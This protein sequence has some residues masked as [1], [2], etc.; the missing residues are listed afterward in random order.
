MHATTATR[1]SALRPSASA[2][3]GVSGLSGRLAAGLL[4][5]LAG[6]AAALAQPSGDVRRGEYIF[7]AAG[8]ASCHSQEEGKGPPLAGGLALKTPYGTFYTPNITPDPVH[9]IGKWSEADFRRALKEGVAPD[10]SLYYPAF[11]YTSYTGMADQDVGDLFAYLKTQAPSDLASKPHE[12]DFPYGWRFLMRGWRLAFFK[13]GRSLVRQDQPADVQRGAYLVG[14]VTH[15]GEC[16]T[17]RNF[18]GA[19]D[20]DRWLSGAEKAATG[21]D[22]VPNITPDPKTGIGDWTEDN[23]LDLLT[24]GSTPDGDRV[25]GE[26]VTTVRNSS[27]QM[28]D[29]DRKAIAHYLKTVKPIEHATP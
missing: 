16:H 17:P 24:D 5:L 20:Y 29:E 10:G 3:S 18:M 19:L 28:T 6:T 15:C 13:P 12:L 25:G 11:P 27:S 1:L 8:C 9:G 23:I 7:H 26:M 14:S 2:G 22:S 4:A 21:T